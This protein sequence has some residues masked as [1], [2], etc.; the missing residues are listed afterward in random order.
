MLRALDAVDGPDAEALVRVVLGGRHQARLD[1]TID[2][3]GHAGVVW[4]DGERLL[5]LATY[6]STGEEAEL[7]A[8]GVVSERRRE[9]IGAALLDAVVREVEDRG[10]RRLWLVTTND[11]LAALAM[12]QRHG[13]RLVE[14]RAGAV[15]RARASN[16]HIPL[17]GSGGILMR[18]ELVLERGLP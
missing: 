12:Y 4:V 14:L 6:I 2:V 7:A 9:G 3:L 18:D 1:T 17:I 13:F 5:G 15:D 16:P 11:N 10:A 8:I